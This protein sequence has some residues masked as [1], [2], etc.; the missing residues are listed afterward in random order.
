MWR[1]LRWIVDW[2][3]SSL[4]RAMVVVVVVVVV[5]VVVVVVVIV[6]VVVLIL[7]FHGNVFLF[8]RRL[9]DSCLPQLYCMQVIPP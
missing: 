8:H 3:H 6:V 1:L 2:H 7:G 9:R 4:S 5:I